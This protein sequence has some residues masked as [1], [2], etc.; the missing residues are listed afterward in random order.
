MTQE[1]TSWHQAS[2]PSREGWLAEATIRSLE[3]LEDSIRRHGGSLPDSTLCHL[4]SLRGSLQLLL[5]S[6]EDHRQG[7]AEDDMDAEAGSFSQV[8]VS[9]IRQLGKDAMEQ[10]VRLRHE[11][12]PS[13]RQ[14][15][16]APGGTVLLG[17]VRQAIASV[18][19]SGS[20]RCITVSARVDGRSRIF[21]G[22]EDSARH[23][24][25]TISIQEFSRW[26]RRIAVLGGE[27][28]LR[29][30]PFGTGTTIE[31]SVPARQLAA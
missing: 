22:I 14:V 20:D 11:F 19:R 27:L 6:S 30:V 24:Q 18:P 12:S 2:L 29:N 7:P 13:L 8:A 25:E 16:F 1:Q 4:N 5:A 23:E 21:I 31:A 28:R 3:A 26:R 9:T 17:L 10:G 15:E